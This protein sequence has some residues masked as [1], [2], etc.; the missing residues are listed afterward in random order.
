MLF[1]RCRPT[2]TLDKT[3]KY[4]L[5]L[6]SVRVFDRTNHLFICT[7]LCRLKN[8]FLSYYVSH[9]CSVKLNC[10][11]STELLILNGAI[12]LGN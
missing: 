6:L 12:G 2:T 8:Y 3:D 11:D 10:K 7:T 4:L 5:G 1:L 9:I